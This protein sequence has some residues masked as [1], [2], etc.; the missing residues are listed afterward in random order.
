MY[1]NVY[2]VSARSKKCGICANVARLEDPLVGQ[3]TRSPLVYPRKQHEDNDPNVL[4]VSQGGF[5]SDG[6]T[7]IEK[8]CGR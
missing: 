6:A 4:A 5:L 2:R 1:F 8:K 7:L 3:M